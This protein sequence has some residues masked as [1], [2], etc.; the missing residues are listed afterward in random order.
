MD[1]TLSAMMDDEAQELELRT[2]LGFGLRMILFIIVPAMV[3]LM[4]V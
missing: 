2:T 3:G 4:M 1:E